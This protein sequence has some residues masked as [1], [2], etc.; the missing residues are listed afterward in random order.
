[1]STATSTSAFDLAE[2]K[3]KTWGFTRKKAEER[4][5]KNALCAQLADGL[6]CIVTIGGTVRLTIASEWADG[7]RRDSLVLEF[8][9]ID[10]LADAVRELRTERS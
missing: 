10:E 7:A 9:E 6:L 2:Q 1:M 8:D 4:H 3:L 5:I